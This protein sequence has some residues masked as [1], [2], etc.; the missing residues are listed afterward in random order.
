MSSEKYSPLMVQAALNLFP[1]IIKRSLLDCSEFTDRLSVETTSRLSLSDLGVS[2]DSK[3]FFGAVSSVLSEPGSKSTVY[4]SE[5]NE[6]A[7]SVE[8]DEGVEFTLLSCGERRARL[9]YFWPIS[10]NAPIRR[11]G[12]EKEAKLIN[13]KGSVLQYWK[14]LIDAAPLSLDDF[15]SFRH[16]ISLTPLRFAESLA[17]KLVRDDCSITDLVP[18][19]LA[20]YE[21]L[22]GLPFEGEDLSSYSEREVKPQLDQL[23]NWDSIQGLQYSL[24][25]SCHSCFV[26]NIDLTG[27]EL[28][29]FLSVLEF[30]KNEGDIFSKVGAVELGL[31]NVERWPE[32]QPFILSI[33]DEL[34]NDDPEDLRGRF[35]FISSLVVLVIGELARTKAFSGKPPFWVRLAAIAH[36]SQIERVYVAAQAMPENFQSFVFESRG[37]Y[38]FMQSLLDMRLEPRWQPDFVSPAQLKFEL[39]GRVASALRLS[40][41][42]LNLPRLTALAVEEVKGKSTILKFPESFLPGPLEGGVSSILQMP[43]EVLAGLEDQLTSDSISLDSFNSLV[44]SSLIFNITADHARLAATAL[45]KVKYQ[46][47]QSGSRNNIF[48]LISGLATVAAVTRSK[49]LAGEVRILSRVTRRRK[50]SEISAE[51]ELRIALV[52]VASVS[53]LDEWSS[54]LGDWLTEISYE[55][56]VGAQSSRLLASL[57]VIIGL[58]PSLAITCSKAEASLSISSC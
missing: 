3:I 57:Q 30:V 15:N 40:Q 49:E 14:E 19:D 48:A 50:D 13:L 45:R 8:V 47:E 42:N 56:E 33:I 31:A 7:L 5:S 52:A 38:F 58:M 22:V 28:K 29:D 9:P 23:L 6:W 24:L 11:A 39:L 17:A 2:F 41:E 21:A 20:Y 46:L 1:S 12:L 51:D 26:S 10:P 54:F 34:I 43:E 36:A 25:F 32:V 37:L 4:D 27:F 44:N 18:L 35:T 55:A 16:D 53:D